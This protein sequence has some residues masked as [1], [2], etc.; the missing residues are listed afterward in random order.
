M[1]QIVARSWI[2]P[3]VWLVDF[4]PYQPKN[5]ADLA[6]LEALSSHQP[7]PVAASVSVSL[8]SVAVRGTDDRPERD[9]TPHNPRAAALTA[10]SATLAEISTVTREDHSG[11]LFIRFHGEDDQRLT[12]R[13]VAWLASVLKVEPS[14]VRAAAAYIAIPQRTD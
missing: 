9:H 5:A 12:A 4:Q 1:P 11:A 7:V 8:T 6:R 13:V 10:T 2:N 14:M 3:D